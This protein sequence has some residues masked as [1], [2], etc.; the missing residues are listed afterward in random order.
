MTLETIDDLSAHRVK[1]SIF[2]KKNMR[3]K[4]MWPNQSSNNRTVCVSVL[5]D[6]QKK[7][8]EIESNFE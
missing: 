6:G 2:R 7:I 4:Y 3:G 1:E 8:E 5:L